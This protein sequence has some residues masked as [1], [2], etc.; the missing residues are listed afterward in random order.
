MTSRTHSKAYLESLLQP[1][2]ISGAIGSRRSSL[3]RTASSLG[4][5][6]G[7]SE[8]NNYKPTKSSG[9]AVE[10]SRGEVDS[11]IG[12]GNGIGNSVEEGI[13][14]DI[15]ADI[16][17]AASISSASE[18]DEYDPARFLRI[19]TTPSRGSYGSVTIAQN[20]QAILNLLDDADLDDEE[21]ID[22]VRIALSK[23][24]SD[25]EGS[26]VVSMRYFAGIV[27]KV[28]IYD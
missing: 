23:R 12:N 24:I 25:A 11:D 10:G 28:H 14:A 1:P 2:P 4:L 5:S 17:K 19:H 6:T 16:T 15:Q 22:Q 9:L 20:V 7:V 8:A 26:Q 13:D 27:L 21:K 18:D 3:T